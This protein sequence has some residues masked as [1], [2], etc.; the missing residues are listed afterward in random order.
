[1][2]DKLLVIPGI[3]ST[4]TFISLEQPFTRQVDIS[5]ITF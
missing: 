3:T 5:H 4:E 1:M 2:F